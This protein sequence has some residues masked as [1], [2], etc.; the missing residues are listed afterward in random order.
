MSV[1]AKD[2][3]N[4]TEKATVTLPGTVEKIIPPIDP[5]EPEKAQIVV[6]GAEE[7]YREIRIE[8]TLQDE[9]GNA[10]SLKKGA[11]VEVTIAA[12]S[13]ATTPKKE[14]EPEDLVPGT[15]QGKEK[16]NSSSS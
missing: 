15:E 8:N 16:K 9:T 11:E 5:D 3:E 6:G 13:E 4:P 14:A 12:E 2:A 7:L 1:K 10:V